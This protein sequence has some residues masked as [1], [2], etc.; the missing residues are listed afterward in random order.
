VR[1]DGP[2]WLLQHRYGHTTQLTT[3]GLDRREEEQK[4][5]MVDQGRGT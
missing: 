5:A 4:A 1:A 3:E 2:E